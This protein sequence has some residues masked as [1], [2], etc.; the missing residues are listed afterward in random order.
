MHSTSSIDNARF[1]VLMN[2]LPSNFGFILGFV[3]PLKYGAASGLTGVKKYFPVDRHI[4]QKVLLCFHADPL[5][6][7]CIKIDKNAGVS[8]LILN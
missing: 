6:F 4:C 1:V 2:N 5:Q 7:F 8:L 3:I